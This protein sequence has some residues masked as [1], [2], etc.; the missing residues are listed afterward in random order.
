V[1][2]ENTTNDR[3]TSAV[4]CGKTLEINMFTVGQSGFDGGKV[5]S[6]LL[7]R[8]RHCVYLLVEVVA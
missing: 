4:L 8:T 7:A 6:D 1:F 3:R 2:R 5:E